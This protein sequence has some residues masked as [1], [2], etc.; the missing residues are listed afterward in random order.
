MSQKGSNA[1]GAYK[2]KIINKERIGL[3]NT[4]YKELGDPDHPDDPLDVLVRVY[5]CVYLPGA[6]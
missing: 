2:D 6:S 4:E 3:D 5:P 1:P